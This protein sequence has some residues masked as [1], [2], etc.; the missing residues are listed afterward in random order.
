MKSQQKILFTAVAALLGGTSLTT[1]ALADIDLK[2]GS[3]TV[4]G[5]IYASEIE[6]ITGLSVGKI[7]IHL[8]PGKSSDTSTAI[9]PGGDT[10]YV[11]VDL[12]NATFNTSSV[13]FG[14]SSNAGIAGTSFTASQTGSI[15]LTDCSVAAATATT[16]GYVYATGGTNIVRYSGGASGQSYA[17]FK[18]KADGVSTNNSGLVGGCTMGI[19]VPSIDVTKG[20]VPVR[21]V[22]NI[23]SAELAAMNDKRTDSLGSRSADL[24]QWAS[25][26]TF[27]RASDSADA[28]ADVTKNFT[29]FKVGDTNVNNNGA[30][31]GRIA[32]VGSFKLGAASGVKGYEGK[33]V[34]LGT[35]IFDSGTSKLIATGD[36]SSFYTSTNSS[37][38]IT[39]GSSGSTANKCEKTTS[40]VK[41]KWIFST[42][43]TTTN[44]SPDS[45]EFTSVTGLFAASGDLSTTNLYLCAELD[46][47]VNAGSAS[48]FQLANS[49]TTFKIMLDP[50]KKTNYFTLPKKEVVLHSIKR[51][52]AV[53][54]APFMSI[55]TGYSK[56]RVV[57]THLDKNGQDSDF[58]INL[59]TDKGNTVTQKLG[60]GVN[61]AGTLKKGSTMVIPIS[62][63]F[64]TTGKSRVMA[65]FVF[66]A[67]NEEIQGVV[68]HINDT[69]GEVTNI[70][71][72]RPGGRD[73]TTK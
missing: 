14:A 45:V 23:Y 8:A 60:G 32:S 29:V 27:E 25:G 7:Q 21:L 42:V 48:T 72:N 37:M 56:S 17:I 13:A 28:V 10:R 24:I 73:G 55:T 2:D 66:Y 62:S 51:D 6:T 41:G 11:R 68:Q 12:E 38:F 33:Q 65:S 63:I 69:T 9:I 53:L 36:F 58:F 20:G 31:A 34:T 22:Y 1:T 26:Y 46:P 3:T 50:I 35:D 18:I 5:A 44:P 57:I 4:Q 67:K 16:G 54:E 30:S 47:T 70:P 71:M 64:E 40:V 15:A 59:T 43:S 61:K 52:G 19:N 39:S 49:G